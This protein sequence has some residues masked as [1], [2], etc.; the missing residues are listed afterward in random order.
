MTDGAGQRRWAHL[1]RWSGYLGT[2]LVALLLT[3]EP[4][5][6]ADVAPASAVPVASFSAHRAWRHLERLAAE[7]G[8]RLTGSPGQARAADYLEQELRGLGLEVVRQRGSG[9]DVIAGMT[10]VYRDLDNVLARLPGRGE[11]TLLLSV[12]YDS[13][14]EGAGAADNALNVAAALEVARALRAGPPLGATILFNF[15]GGEELGLLGAAAFVRHPWFSQVSGFLNLDASGGQGRQLLLR[16]TAR[17]GGLLEAYVSAAPHPHGTVVAQEIFSLLPFDTDFRV[18]DEAGLPGLDLAPYEDTYAYHTALDRVERVALRTVQDVGDNVLATLRAA[19]AAGAA[20]AADV[21]AAGGRGVYFDVLGLTMVRWSSRLALGLG[22]AVVAATALLLVLPCG[23][24]RGRGA[25]ALIGGATVVLSALLALLASLGAG[26]LLVALGE[27]MSWFARPWLAV[28]CYATFALGGVVAAQALVRLVARRF[29]PA[30]LSD[31]ATRGLLV[32][33]AALALWAALAEVGSSYVPLVWWLASALALLGARAGHPAMRWGLTLGGNLV[34]AVLWL[35]VARLV[36]S[37][38]V[39]VT[40]MLGAEAPSEL[41]IAALCGG[42]AL[43]VVLALTPLLQDL[44]SLRWPGLAVV[45]SALAAVAALWLA[46]PYSAARPKRTYVAV[47][48]RADG[49]AQASVVAVDAG[50]TVPGGAQLVAT[51]PAARQPTIELGPP[52]PEGLRVVRVYAP[53]AYQAELRFDGALGSWRTA[54][55]VRT[56]AEFIWVGTS[57]PLELQ[58]ARRG[59]G[60]L[61]LHVHARYQG[62]QAPVTSVTSRLPAWSVVAVESTGDATA[63]L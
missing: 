18:Y 59:A 19:G 17:T 35:Q 6:S 60:R 58:V 48:P 43:P 12:H 16:T 63:E 51:L 34:A 26:M 8:N 1:V 9:A 55:G 61:Q 36:I 39:P 22:L 21:R 37:S 50:P 45:A 41:L 52:G 24:G 30:A 57:A 46:F 47:A 14:S 13:A 33:W 28:G 27:S 32:V 10:Y 25:A 49:T 62:A 40:G 23:E 3:S 31:V 44:P 2:L 38:L 56:A 53:G 5:R 29:T 4:W 7:I 11:G 42:A 20:D 54:D 15:N